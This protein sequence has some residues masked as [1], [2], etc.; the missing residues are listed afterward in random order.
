MSGINVSLSEL[1]DLRREAQR[2]SL[3]S[4]RKIFT[5]QAGGYL[6]AFR[7]RGMDF[8]EVRAYQVGDDIRAM[9]WRVLARTGEPHTKV[10]HEERERP[11]F[12]IN[13]FSPSM[14]FGT[15]VAF[16][17]VIAAQTAALMAWSAVQHGDRV[18]GIIFNDERF[19][20]LR[21]RSRKLGLLPFLQTLV[22]FSQLS[23]G[24]FDKNYLSKA[25]QSMRFVAKPGSLIILI[26]DFSNLD[27][28]V[29][30]HW[31]ALAHNH[32]LL[33]ISIY[34]QLEQAP[35][36]PGRYGISNGEQICL[37]DTSDQ[38]FC[39]NYQLYFAERLE[40]LEKL[41]RLTQTKLIKLA[42]NADIEQELILQ[43]RGVK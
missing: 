40:K 12:F 7:G 21:P 30:L 26:S 3:F 35:P 25:L 28:K 15:K 19:E 31:Q 34:D 2:L 33:A 8:D 5:K 43:L 20:Q 32:D 13:D 23:S 41:C 9:D 16:K 14:F 36:K 37:M 1:I 27:E 4:H 11:V 22:K 39:H 42:T 17:S 24:Q 29:N 6:S 38:K 10:Y 18:G